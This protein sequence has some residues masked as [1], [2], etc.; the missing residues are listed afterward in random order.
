M[1]SSQTINELF[2]QYTNFEQF[3]CPYF[4]GEKEQF[5]EQT[6]KIIFYFPISFSNITGYAYKQF[7]LILINN[8]KRVERATRMNNKY[9]CQNLNYIGFMKIYLSVIIHSNNNNISTATP[10]N[11]FINYD[12]DNLNDL[13]SKYDGG[14]KGETILF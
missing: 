8:M 10:P 1:L 5:L 12:Y 7:G 3:Y 4:G 13:Y 9:F 14:D 11:T 6:F 2:E